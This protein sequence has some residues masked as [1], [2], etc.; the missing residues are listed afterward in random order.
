MLLKNKKSQ[1]VIKNQKTAEFWSFFM[2]LTFKADFFPHSFN[3]LVFLFFTNDLQTLMLLLQNV[4]ILIQ[5]IINTVEIQLWVQ[6]NS[7][8]FLHGFIYLESSSRPSALI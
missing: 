8:Y 2:N 4:L 7:P 5:S 1:N 3:Y 6:T